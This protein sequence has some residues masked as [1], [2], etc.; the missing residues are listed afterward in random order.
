MSVNCWFLCKRKTFYYNGQRSKLFVVISTTIKRN[1]NRKIQK[2]YDRKFDSK[3][4]LPSAHRPKDEWKADRWTRWRTHIH[5]HTHAKQ[6]QST[7]KY[8]LNSMYAHILYVNFYYTF[9]SIG[10]VVRCTSD[11]HH[12]R[13]HN[14]T[15][16][17]TSL[18]GFIYIFGLH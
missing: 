15:H 10:C 13:T 7:K 5:T 16:C 4:C 3:R 1:D 17:T 9:N 6:F 2:N 11:M 18:R 14:T 12:T 8:T